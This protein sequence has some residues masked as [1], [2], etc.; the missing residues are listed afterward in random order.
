MLRGSASAKRARATSVAW[1]VW[2]A[3]RRTC[4]PAATPSNTPR[5]R[6]KSSTSGPVAGGSRM[7]RR[8]E[9]VEARRRMVPHPSGGVRDVHR[10]LVRPRPH[11]SHRAQRKAETVPAASRQT[12][13]PTRAAAVVR[14]RPPRPGSARRPTHVPGLLRL[15]RPGRVEPP[16]SDTVGPNHR[17]APAPE[18]HALR[19]RGLVDLGDRSSARA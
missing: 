12:D 8:H 6:K 17:P 14:H 7:Q 2:A 10:T 4:E 9:H 16:R 19:R 13:L 18:A 5:V 1:L 11:S 3:S 15:R